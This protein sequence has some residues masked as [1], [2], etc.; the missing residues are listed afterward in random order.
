MSNKAVLTIEPGTVILADTGSS[1]T[2]IITKGATIIA[3]GLE[4]DP[5]VFTSNKAMKKAGDWGG[6]I[7]LGDAHTNKFVNFS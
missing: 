4:T 3:E 1:A 5:I 2:L 7:L 6:I